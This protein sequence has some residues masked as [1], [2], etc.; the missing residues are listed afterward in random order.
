MS[1]YKCT[2]VC[3]PFNLAEG[4]HWQEK[5]GCV[6]F[7]DAFVG[8][9]YKF[10]TNSKALERKQIGGC[11]TIIIPWEGTTDHFVLSEGHELFQFEWK[12]GKRQTL[13]FIE[14]NE[15]TRFNDG[16]CD[17][18]NRLW[19]GTMGMETKPAVVPPEMGS[20][21]CVNKDYSVDQKVNKVSLS[22]GIGWSPDNYFLYFSDSAK[23]KVYVFDYKDD[24]GAVY[25][26]RVFVD[27]DKIGKPGEV[28]DGL[29]VDVTGKVW[30]AGWDGNRV[31]RVDPE[32]GKIINEVKVEN[33]S[34]VTSLCFGG[35]EMNKL[36]V[37][38]AWKGLSDEKRKLQP[39]AGSIFEVIFPKENIKGFF[40]D[41]FAGNPF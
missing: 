15:Q 33:V 37:T 27:Y 9:V 26:Q 10:D 18:R 1:E 25:N 2:P 35:P 36:Y 40:G 41:C 19:I 12:T 31:I 28:P 29:T 32:T 16:K 17:R 21:Y 11:V 13:C 34:Q 8:D 24:T 3:G 30:I 39:S 4:P 14:K 7:V 6:Y 22:N 23:R 20:L 5:N 38:S